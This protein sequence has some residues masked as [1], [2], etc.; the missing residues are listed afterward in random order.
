M[1]MYIYIYIYMY[2]YEKILFAVEGGRAELFPSSVAWHQRFG[3]RVRSRVRPLRLQLE[4]SKMG[5]SHRSE[6]GR[7]QN[8]TN[9][10]CWEWQWQPPQK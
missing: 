5:S 10:M 7:V 8:P 3:W 2:I 6:V 4:Q 9:P 1:Y